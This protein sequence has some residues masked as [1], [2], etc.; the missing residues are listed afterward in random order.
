MC[1]SGRLRMHLPLMVY[2]TSVIFDVVMRYGTMRWYVLCFVYIL[3][4]VCVVLCV[5]INCDVYG[6]MNGY[7]R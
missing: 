4:S 5:Y 6:Y 3:E 1:K 2:V 7:G